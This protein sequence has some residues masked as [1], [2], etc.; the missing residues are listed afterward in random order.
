MR[1]R[2]DLLAKAVK[3]IA[4]AETLVA[5]QAAIV[6]LFR[7][8]GYPLELAND[9]LWTMLISLDHMRED[10]AHIERLAGIKAEF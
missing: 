10:K 9:L 2:P 1:S 3:H 4:D 8:K 5:R 6:D 7:R